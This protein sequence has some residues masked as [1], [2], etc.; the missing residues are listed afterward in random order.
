MAKMFAVLMSKTQT[1]VFSSWSKAARKQKAIRLARIKFLT[2]SKSIRSSFAVNKWWDFLTTSRKERTKEHIAANNYIKNLIHNVFGLWK[3]VHDTGRYVHI[4]FGGLNKRYYRDSLFTGLSAIKTFAAEASTSSKWKLKAKDNAITKAMYT[5]AKKILLKNFRKWV[6]FNSHK[7]S[8]LSKVRRAIL[9]SLHRK[10][11]T[12]FDLWQECFLIKKTIENVNRGG[13]V[14]IENSMLKER[15][16]ILLKLIEDEGLDQRYVERYINERENL[17]AALKRKGIG[18]LRYKAGL[19]NPNDNSLIPRL[20]MTWKLWVIKRKRIMRYAHRMLAYRKKSDLMKGFL[21]WKRG[22]PLVVNTINKM[23]RREI[24]GLVAKMDRDIKTLE[25]RLENT[26]NELVYMHAYSEVLQTH[27]KRGQNLALSIGKNNIHKTFHR[28]FLRWTVHTNLCKIH[29][30]LA[31]LTSV[32]E[33]FYVTKTTIKALEEDNQQMIE[34]NMELRQA[35]LDGI[36]IAEAF[37]TLSKERERLSVDL[38]ERTATIKRL[39]EHNNELALK[40]KHFSADDK[41][42]T[43]D[44]DL[45]KTK[46]Y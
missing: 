29:D 38:A 5:K 23:P 28:V 27:T 18:R 12:S 2:V 44:R 42:I 11:R 32:E 35:S 36:A 46:K 22:F 6:D 13:V 4:V 39:L 20:F 14:A 34:E 37:E 1:L 8:A 43:P 26:N 16:D 41:Y 17:K 33:N 10:F 9:R 15:N 24:Y 19:I 40:L 7:E 30:L 21:T 25:G 3:R 45:Y 31:Q